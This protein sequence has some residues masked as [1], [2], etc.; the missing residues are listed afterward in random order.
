MAFSHNLFSRLSYPFLSSP[1]GSMEMQL[2]RVAERLHCFFGQNFLYPNQ[3][4]LLVSKSETASQLIITRTILPSLL[5]VLFLYTFHEAVAQLPYL[6][7]MWSY[8]ATPGL[9]FMG[10][11]TTTLSVQTPNTFLLLTT[12][13]RCSSYCWAFKLRAN[14]HTFFFRGN[15]LLAILYNI[16]MTL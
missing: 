16:Y 14:S 1:D 2:L 7:P 12:Q 10:Q 15:T 9:A 5:E 13:Q 6:G 4:I 8:K 3:Q 11:V